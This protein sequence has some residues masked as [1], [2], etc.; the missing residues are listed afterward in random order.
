MYYNI[1]IWLKILAES[2]KLKLCIILAY[3]TIPQLQLKHNNII[4]HF[5]SKNS[6]NRFLQ[7][8]NNNLLILFL[9]YFEFKRKKN[10][11]YLLP[12]TYLYTQ[13]V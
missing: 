8:G 5:D 11:F 3:Y 6:N 10:I 13:L 2:L 12:Y 4:V 7:V 1:I 9:A